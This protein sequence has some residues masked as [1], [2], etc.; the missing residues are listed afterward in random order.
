[1]SDLRNIL[2]PT[3]S[4]FTGPSYGS[5]ALSDSNPPAC[6][7]L[8]ED[9]SPVALS[10]WGDT[11]PSSSGTSAPG[12]L[13]QMLMSPVLDFTAGGERS[14]N[15]PYGQPLVAPPEFNDTLK[16]FETQ[17]SSTYHRTQSLA[18]T[19]F[20][21]PPT[22]FQH[23]PDVPSLAQTPLQCTQPSVPNQVQVPASSPSDTLQNT[24]LC[25]NAFP[26]QDPDASSISNSSCSPDM[27]HILYAS[28]LP[29]AFHLPDASHLP[30]VSHLPDA[31]HLPDVSHLPN[32]SHN[33]NALHLPDVPYIPNASAIPD[34]SSIP[35]ASCVPIPDMSPIPDAPHIS[36]APQAPDV[37]HIPT[38]DVS[39]AEPT[40][41]LVEKAPF[42]TLGISP[43][44][45]RVM[46]RER[47]T[48]EQKAKKSSAAA[49]ARAAR[50]AFTGELWEE[51][52]KFN[53]A[54]EEICA[55]HSQKSERGFELLNTSS[56]FKPGA[57]NVTKRNALL[58][59]LKKELNDDSGVKLKPAELQR[60]LNSELQAIVASPNE[61]E[62][63]KQDV[64]EYWEQKAMGA[65]IS[66]TSSAQDV[67]LFT[68]SLTTE[69]QNLNARTG[70][71]GCFFIVGGGRESRAIPSWGMAGGEMMSFFRK[72]LGS[73]PWDIL[74]DLQMYGSRGNKGRGVESSAAVRSQCS[75]MI[76]SMLRLTLQ[77]R[78]AMN[79]DS[80]ETAIVD[81]YKI[82]LT[83][84]N[85][86]NKGVVSNPTKLS[87]EDVR[88]LHQALEVGTCRW[89]E[90]G[91]KEVENRAQE[92]ENSDKPTRKRRSDAGV[93]RGPR[94]RVR[95]ANEDA[96]DVGGDGGN[97][98]TPPSPSTASPDD[99]GPTNPSP[100]S[101]PAP[102]STSSTV[103]STNSTAPPTLNPA[104]PFTTISF[105]CT[106]PT[107]QNS[108][109]KPSATK[110]QPR[111]QRSDAGKPRGPRKK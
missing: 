20:K 32:A 6:P 52:A 46:H 84:P 59:W 70:A 38:T 12:P 89:V 54:V 53:K 64:L 50:E 27:S 62:R 69:F 24:P 57:R 1:M 81:R 90:V 33:P 35:D 48:K 56:H 104:E 61:M 10:S 92:K 75:N 8:P 66:P 105:Q 99:V 111:K 79:Y 45:P 42:R 22:S 34:A 103:P 71:I 67:R 17:P 74:A 31:S 86:C 11:F 76:S 13:M 30:D 102:I 98:Q 26:N 37:F 39:Q 108:A 55:K 107:P 68:D 77:S 109:P 51:K 101:D 43:Q 4:A 14:M 72:E 110:K 83:W 44:Y 28:Q 95:V 91:K 85:N 58:H 16:Q 97:D 3:P 15:A 29:N 82:R 73:E 88:V 19:E 87:V 78:V 100:S 80:Y 49:I 5:D 2:N 94:K 106:P 41:A 60:R 23:N 96:S 65:R 25:S 9:T 18:P 40:D 63:L 47:L 36:D 21:D 93:A 7:I